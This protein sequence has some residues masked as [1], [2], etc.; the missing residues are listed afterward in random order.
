MATAWRAPGLMVIALLAA[1]SVSAQ[2]TTSEGKWRIG[3]STGAYVPFASLITAADENDTQLEAGPA[4]SLDV[5]YQ[6][7][8]IAA[9][10]AHG[11]MAFGAV[12]LGSSIQPE[13]LGPSNQVVLGTATGGVLLAPTGWLGEYISP[14]LRLGV[15]L[16]L[17][18]FDLSGAQN[19]SQLT[20]DVGVGVRGIGLGPIEVTAEARYLPSSFDQSKLPIRGIEGQKQRQ[21]DLVLAVGF[22]I[23]TGSPQVKAAQ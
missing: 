14:T 3:A 23:R 16:K 2:S 18:R 15:G 8:N 13:V 11:L 20:A 7:Q 22:A 1:A 9:V 21:S 6:V 17:Y 12:Q 4:F 10:Y 5:Q 19:Q